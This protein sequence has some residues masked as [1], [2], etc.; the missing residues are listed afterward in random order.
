M[1]T[2]AV[3][4][5][6]EE[7][8]TAR[9]ADRIAETLEASGHDAAVHDVDALPSTFDPAAA[10]AVLVGGSIHAGTHA[11]AVVAF[12]REHRETL[13][14]RPSGFVQVCLTAALDGEEHRA[15]AAGYVEDF[16]AATGWDPDRTAV[17]AGA[18][19]Y[20]EYGFLKRALLKQIA[21]ATTGDTDTSR[22]YEYTD[23]HAVETFA[24]EFG[25]FV[26]AET[27]ETPVAADAGGTGDE[28]DEADAAGARTVSPR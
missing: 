27:G 24:R 3:V 5:G 25:A 8:Q 13:A 14:D 6:S 7:G 10:D 23:W 12:A 19:R 11:P 16:R 21:K 2:I 28:T 4:Y 9:V 22:D 26:A 20:T 15:E 18:L 1:A 17:F